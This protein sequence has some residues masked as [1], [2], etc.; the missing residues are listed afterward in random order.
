MYIELKNAFSL[1][2]FHISLKNFSIPNMLNKHSLYTLS[3]WFKQRVTVCL[4]DT[5]V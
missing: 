5:H 3:D 2:I 1:G 4:K